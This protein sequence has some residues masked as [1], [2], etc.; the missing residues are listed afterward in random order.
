MVR[1]AG[2][3][4]RLQLTPLVYGLVRSGLLQGTL[5]T[6]KTSLIEKAKRTVNDA[7][8][9]SLDLLSSQP[10]SDCRPPQQVSFYGAPGWQMHRCRC[11]PLLELHLGIPGVCARRR[12]EM[13]APV[14]LAMNCFLGNKW[15]P[16]SRCIGDTGSDKKTRT[17]VTA[18][19]HG[20]GPLPL[21]FPTAAQVQ[22]ADTDAAGKKKKTQSTAIKQIM[23]LE[24]AQGPGMGSA[25]VF[26]RCLFCVSLGRGWTGIPR[27]PWLG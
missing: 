22:A 18:A 4:A 13:P 24:L 14:F 16:P 26:I 6:F 23:L 11:F 8:T 1:P 15:S 19:S 5:Q 27:N 2:S 9:N 20:G 10:H 12:T 7:I 25:F 3:P 21:G 17:R